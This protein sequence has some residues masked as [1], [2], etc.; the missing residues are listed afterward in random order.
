MLKK[1][2]TDAD[3]SVGSEWCKGVQ[4]ANDSPELDPKKSD[5]NQIWLLNFSR[6]KIFFKRF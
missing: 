2:L 5:L 3:L 4:M 1:K 6:I